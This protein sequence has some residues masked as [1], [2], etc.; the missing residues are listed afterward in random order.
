MDMRQEKGLSILLYISRIIH[1]PYRIWITMYHADKVHLSS[2][3]RP[4]NNFSEKY[5]KRNRVAI[6][7][8]FL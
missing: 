4:L 5:V 8:F 6:Y 7:P 2:Y 1:D 3:G